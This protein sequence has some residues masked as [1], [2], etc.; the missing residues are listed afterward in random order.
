V[1]QQPTPPL[2][3]MAGVHKSFGTT[4]ALEGVDLRVE[5]GECV[6]I[7]GPNGAGK[8]TVIRMIFGLISP[9]DGY[10]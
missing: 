1:I 9:T 3:E 6:A 2:I 10:V 5:C 7:L 4:R 8:T